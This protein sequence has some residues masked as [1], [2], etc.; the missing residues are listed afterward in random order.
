MP[1]ENEVKSKRVDK[2]GG[3]SQASSKAPS[4]VPSWAENLEHTLRR[5][6]A[7]KQKKRLQNP[8]LYR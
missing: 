8:G 7:E 2:S 3:K 1:R 5:I 4:K 6:N